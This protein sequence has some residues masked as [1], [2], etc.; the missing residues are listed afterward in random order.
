MI[1]ADLAV[2][3]IKIGRDKLFDLLRR[4]QLLIRRRKRFAVTT[5]SD[6]GFKVY[7]NL[8]HG[9]Q[10]KGRDQ[11]WV[12]DITYLKT[13][14]GFVYLFLITDAYSRNIVGWNIS[15]SL[16]VEGALKAL[17]MALR[18]CRSTKNLIHHSDRGIQYCCKAYTSQ[19]RSRDIRISMAA[20]GDCYE[21]AMA[22]RMNGILKEEYMLNG[23]FLDK[24]HSVKATA[25]AI[26]LYS[27]YRPHLALNM[28]KPNEVHQWP[29]L[30]TYP[31]VNQKE[32]RNKKE[33]SSNSNSVN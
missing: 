1:K 27:K 13:R 25:A 6:H 10:P 21:N 20:K 2:Q 5:D 33:K 26:E 8:I 14:R 9:W 3:G 18:Q 31:R 11:L 23:T 28:R 17:K 29:E 4:K 7:K 24:Y 16:G 30:C 15:A 12:T 19:L 32:K 22:E